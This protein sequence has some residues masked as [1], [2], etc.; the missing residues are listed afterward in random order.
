MTDVTQLIVVIPENIPGKEL[1]SDVRKP[2][3][4]GVCSASFS[5]LVLYVTH[6]NSHQLPKE[7]FHGCLS[8]EKDEMQDW[9]KCQHCNTAFP[10]ICQMET[11]LLDV[12]N[13]SNFV[14]NGKTKMA[15]IVADD[16]CNKLEDLCRVFFGKVDVNK[17]LPQSKQV[18]TKNVSKTGA[19]QANNML[20]SNS[21][22]GAEDKN[23]ESDVDGKTAEDCGLQMDS[24]ETERDIPEAETFCELEPDKTVEKPN[25]IHTCKRKKKTEVSFYVLLCAFHFKVKDDLFPIKLQ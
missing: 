18:Q 24:Y 4:C 9:Y 5:S 20:N 17:P 1:L 16:I 6:L 7:H 19:S 14:I 13:T 15:S 25:P 23:R 3:V 8:L 12:E 11:H 22:S 21:N 10:T 2:F